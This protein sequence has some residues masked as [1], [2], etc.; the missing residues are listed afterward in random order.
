[1]ENDNAAGFWDDE[2]AEKKP[3]EVTDDGAAQW[4]LR[5]IAEAEAE[6][7]RWKEHYET[8]LAMMN[9]RLDRT[10]GFFE[11]KLFHYFNTVP[12]KTT[13]TQEVYALPGGRLIMKKQQPKIEKD[14][15]VLVKWLEENGMRDLVKVTKSADWAGLKKCVF[16]DGGKVITLDGEVVPGL[17][18]TELP[19][20]FEVRMEA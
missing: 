5:K 12:H 14:N 2:A 7:A 17:T 9:D 16:V 3:F 20:A 19:D 4:C 10:I 13:R 18:V 6:R 8:Q 11:G 15:T 1:M